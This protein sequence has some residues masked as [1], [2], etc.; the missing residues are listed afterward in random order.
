MG[1]KKK[2]PAHITLKMYLMKLNTT[3]FFFTCLCKKMQTLLLPA[4]PAGIFPAKSPA[5]ASSPP[6]FLRT[7]RRPNLS[8]LNS[9]PSFKSLHSLSSSFSSSYITSSQ[10]TK[11]PFYLNASSQV[12]TFTPSNDESEKE[13]LSQVFT[14]LHCLI[15]LY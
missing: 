11:N 4:A 7:F 13:K 5:T 8:T 15:F 12:S 14:F 9:P 2:E 1:S 10:L 3:W 6:Q